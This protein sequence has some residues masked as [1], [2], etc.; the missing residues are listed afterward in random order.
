MQTG[1]AKA[2]QQLQDLKARL[3]LRVV[4]EGILGPATRHS[5]QYV[6]YYAPHRQEDHPSLTVWADG[7][8]DFGHHEHQGDVFTFLNLYGGMDFRSALQFLTNEAPPPTSPITSKSPPKQA[9]KLEARWQKAASRILATCQANLRHDVKLQAYLMQ[10]GYT[11]QLIEARG[12]G[13]NYAWTPLD[14]KKADGKHAWLPPGIVYP[15]FKNGQ[16]YGLKVRLPYH[17]KDDS[18]DEL[19][20][21]MR[22]KPQDAKYMQVAGGRLAE[23]W[24]GQLDNPSLPVILVE[25]EKDCD[26]LSLRLAGKA[27]ILTLG[28]A[29]GQIPADLIDALLPVPWVAVV[30]DNDAAGQL[31]S[32][33][34]RQTLQAQFKAQAEKAQAIG[35]NPPIPAVS[36]GN[37][38]TTYKDISDW[39]L[40]EQG[41]GVGA[42]FEHLREWG[43]Y[44]VAQRNFDP[45]RQTYFFQG[46]P[47]VLR[48]TL[49]SLHQIIPNGKKYLKDQANAL[50]VL[51]IRQEALQHHKLRDD[52]ALNTQRLSELAT[53][54][55][56]DCDQYAIRRGLEQLAGLGFVELIANLPPSFKVSSPTEQIERGNSAN[57]SHRRGRP[58]LTYQALPLARALDTLLKRLETQL[59]IAVY[60][61]YLPERVS[62]K[63]FS[64]ILP[65][66]A[67]AEVADL[68]ES[69]SSELYSDYQRDIRRAQRQVFKRMA[70]YR[71]DLDMQALFEAESTILPSAM[72]FSSG[73][74]LREVYYRA[75]IEAAGPA[76]RQQS[77][78]KSAA[79][80]GVTLKTLRRLRRRVGVVAEARYEYF[81]IMQGD[82]VHGAA[83]RL[84]PWAS[85]RL[86]GRYFESSSGGIIRLDMNAAARDTAWVA[87]QLAQGWQVRLKIQVASRERLASPAELQAWRECMTRNVPIRRLTQPEPAEHHRDKPTGSAAEAVCGEGLARA[88]VGDQL[89]LRRHLLSSMLNDQLRLVL[90]HYGL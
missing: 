50:L 73:R 38:P 24:Y 30:L 1:L 75:L 20:R 54:L 52:E 21:L 19:A 79:Q 65:A 46:V 11:W 15:W 12:L 49:L 28:S 33:R 55:G 87:A 88:Y 31:N 77:R 66:D 89:R 10:Q 37:V 64:D 51:E 18:P 13:V 90:R 85:E 9:A 71:R 43:E 8:K 22:I 83:R 68:I 2:N 81:D 6:Q 56:R 17:R 41:A 4:A 80:L 25:G 86:Y 44:L 42:W 60:R 35:Q 27:N 57:N 47:N 78:A 45:Q 84:A 76:G 58:S 36:F 7:F 14:W 29:T 82:D 5:R 40:G 61:D 69:V 62:A 67:A 16:L 39:I 72:A 70:Q 63:W 59:Q 53:E 32:H 48:E 26:N 74:E 34:L 3:D 23:T